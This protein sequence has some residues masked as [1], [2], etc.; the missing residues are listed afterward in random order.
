MKR[1]WRSAWIIG[2]STGLGRELAL[3]LAQAGTKTFISA[4]SDKTLHS[5]ERHNS[6][7]MAVPLDVTDHSACENAVTSVFEEN[8]SLPELIILNAAIYVPLKLE[9]FDVEEISKMNKVNYMGVVHMIDALRNY[10]PVKSP[11]TLA[12]VTSPSG[13]RGLPGGLGYGSS[14][15]AVINLFESIKPESE[16]QGV[17]LRLIN[18]GFIKT[19]LTDQNDFEMPQLMTAEKAASRALD[20]LNS[21]KFNISFPNP[22]ILKLRILNLLPDSVYFWIMR[23]IA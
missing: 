1:V 15:A 3:K 17:D 14:K 12:A 16:Q 6:N 21:N 18:P 13:W 4:R 22:F 23:K 5:L 11:T 9:N 2:A 7:L 20:G 8:G 19:R 10:W